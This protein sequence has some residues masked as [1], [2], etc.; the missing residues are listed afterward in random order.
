MVPPR[1]PTKNNDNILQTASTAPVPPS[2]TT[3]ATAPERPRGA[4]HIC[5]QKRCYMN[6]IFDSSRDPLY[7]AY[8]NLIK[9]ALDGT[10]PRPLPEDVTP[11]DICAVG[12]SNMTAHMI[13]APLA[14]LGYAIT[15]DRSPTSYMNKLLEQHIKAVSRDARQRKAFD[16]ITHLL[17]ES[18]IDII[19][20][21][22]IELKR[23]YPSPHLRR[24]SDI[25][26]VI[27]ARGEDAG[28]H[29]LMI[30]LGY[31]CVSRGGGHHDVYHR[32][33]LL[34]VELHR[35]ADYPG[36]FEAPG[37]LVPDKSIPGIYRL[38][39]EDTFVELLRHN[40]KHMKEGGLGVRAVCDMYVLTRIYG[41]MIKCAR[42]RSRLAEYGL[43]KFADTLNRIT[44]DLFLRDTPLITP[45]GRVLLTGITYGGRD[46]AEMM[47][48]ANGAGRSKTA[49]LRLRLFPGI[50]IMK[51]RYPSLIKYPFFLPF[52]WCARGF[53]AILTPM[54][55]PN[56]KSAIKTLAAKDDTLEKYEFMVFEFGLDSVK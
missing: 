36:Y 12:L 40:A 29:D 13:F 43:Q 4:A 2:A 8:I 18:G 1:K 15:P 47:K 50:A 34:N 42:I 21:K 37:G 33:P 9:S 55:R 23:L 25:D 46:D 32:E 53:Y 5:R 38:T 20:I 39:P 10:P 7:S 16:E 11:E 44:T 31:T 54:R 24:M 26:I 14:A 17:T 22:G 30:S 27:D 48:L 56:I 49:Y 28:V 3:T 35:R 6:D 19:P 51:K 52:C 41:D 45:A